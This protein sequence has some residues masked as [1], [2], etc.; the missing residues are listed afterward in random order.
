MELHELTLTSLTA[1]SPSYFF[2]SCIWTLP[3]AFS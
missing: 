2:A 1:G 3:Q